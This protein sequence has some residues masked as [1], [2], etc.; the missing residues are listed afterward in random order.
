MIAQ[1]CG[2]YGIDFDAELTLMA[3]D[4]GTSR[5][6]RMQP[7]SPRVSVVDSLD[8]ADLVIR[9]SDYDIAIVTDGTPRAVPLTRELHV[10]DPWNSRPTPRHIIRTDRSPEDLRYELREAFD[11]REFRDDQY[12]IL[13]RALLREDVI[14]L[15]PTGGGKSLTF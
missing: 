3:H 8:Q 15:L 5:V 7:T 14:G 12:A 10:T 1:L 2:L 11:V 4:F 13:E 9:N 6:V